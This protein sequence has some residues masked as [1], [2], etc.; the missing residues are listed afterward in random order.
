MVI[1]N[2]DHDL[3][4][5]QNSD[6][7]S[8]GGKMVWIPPGYELALGQPPGQPP[9]ESQSHLWDYL[10][11]VWRHRL[12]VL[13]VFLA[14]V[15]IAAV[16]AW[17]EVPVYVATAKLR[18]QPEASGRIDLFQGENRPVAPRNSIATQLQ[19]LASRKLAEKVVERLNLYPFPEPAAETDQVAPPPA[20][21]LSLLARAWDYVLPQAAVGMPPS[22]PGGGIPSDIGLQLRVN[23]FRAGLTIKQVGETE[24]VAV[25]YRSGSPAESARIANAFCEEY[26]RWIYDAKF[27]S[28]NHARQWLKDKLDEMK[29]KLEASQEQLLKVASG[30]DYIVSTE[31]ISQFSQPLEEQRQRLAEAQRSLFEKEFTL[32]GLESEDELSP[33]PAMSDPHLAKLQQEYA[34]LLIRYDKQMAQMGPELPAAK[35]MIAEKKRLEA[36]LKEV[37]AQA[38]QKA[39]FEYN[40][41]QANYD[42]LQKNHDGEHRRINEI[43][44]G[45]ILFGILKRDVDIN[46]ELYHGLLQRWKEV[47]MA[48]TLQ[49]D[50][51]SVM[52]AAL[53]PMRPSMHSKSRTLLIGGFL[54][55]F[56]AIGLAFF[57]E[58][59][60]TTIKSPEEGARIAR[61][62][63]LAYIPHFN[64]P[65]ANGRKPDPVEM[66]V[67]KKPGSIF[68]ES[69]RA[70]RTSILHGIPGQSPKTLLVTSCFPGEGKTTVALNLA[71]AFAQR[72]EMVLLIDADIKKPSL[73]EFFD[74]DTTLGLSDVLT[75]RFDGQNFPETKIPNLMVVP[76]GPRAPNPVELL[77][78]DIMRKFLKRSAAEYDRIILDSAPTMNLVDTTVLA[79]YVD[80]VLLVAQPGKTPRDALS[81]VRDKLTDVQGPLLGLVFNNQVGAAARHYGNGYEYGHTSRRYRSAYAA[82]QDP[83]DILDV[84]VSP[85]DPLSPP[86]GPDRPVK[87]A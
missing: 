53:T 7:S 26:V 14:C 75:G 85:V 40:Q 66:L 1:E 30:K 3:I 13:L 24:I 55:L 72:G 4:R 38:R 76:S 52:E 11:L 31:N 50:N 56:L 68:A 17:R 54:G 58:Y 70:L 73:K 19:I 37:R 43:Q 25:Q 16:K 39:Q 5:P 33:L 65:R 60:D 6:P 64:Q 79:P 51:V 18:I 22:G 63:V 67:Q 46:R 77:D 62:P 41:A 71:I 21:Q 34:N 15:G 74:L 27:D 86:D 57:V 59:M 32:K 8:P 9:A 47:G 29:S 23:R 81:C 12:L 35:P 78:S 45:L 36:Q 87:A 69:I 80:G 2:H 10:W 83:R 49:P 82:G 44:R 42:F 61:L 20:A 84:A 28:Y 48:T